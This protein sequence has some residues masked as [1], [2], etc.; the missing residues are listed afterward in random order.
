MNQYFKSTDADWVKQ[1]IVGFSLFALLAFS[2]LLARLVYL[3]AVMGEDYQRLS[4]NNSIRLQII[5]PPRGLILDAGGV[6]LAEN[7]PSFD[8]IF[9]PKDAGDARRVLGD[10]AAYLQVPDDDLLSR[11]KHTRGL[12]AF[13]PVVLRQDIG[14]DALAVVEARKVDLPGVQ[15][16]VRIRR[17]YLQGSLAAHLIGYLGE[18]SP[19]DL[20]R[21]A[22]TGLR[23]GDT[24]GKS[25]VEREFD[26]LLRGE[27]GGRQV[28]VNA[29]G[30][31]MRVLNTVAARP[32][33][34][35]H[36]TIDHMLQERTEQL[37][38]GLAAAAVA[39]DPRTGRILA[40]ASS[41][42]FSP[43]AFVGG[44]D[45]PRWEAMVSHPFR[46]LENKAIQ[47]EYP[48]G[49]TYKIV[50]ALAG[51]EEKVIDETSVFDCA[52]FLSF[53]G[54]DYRC[55][56]KEGHGRVDIRRAMAESCDVFFYRV[57]Q[58]LG[59]DRLAWYAKA[60]GLGAA[61][62]IGLEPESRGLIPS[63]VWKKKRFGVPWQDGETLSIAIGQGYNLTTPLQMAM[64]TAAVGND[65][66]RHRPQIL[67]R[68]ETME[69]ALVH[70]SQPEAL[71]KLPASPRT[72]ALIQQGLSAV[73]NGERGTARRVHINDI[74][75]AGKTGTSQVVGR[76]EG[77]D[78][79]TPPHLRPH[80]WFVCYAPVGSPR[81]AIAVVVENGE[82]GSSAAGPI[83][84][85][86]VKT[87]LRRPAAD[88]RLALEMSGTPGG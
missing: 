22:L 38:E 28:E 59:V 5:D 10:L 49:S 4:V 14:R 52:G 64:L 80:A 30:Q 36:L 56:K 33:H 16:D 42:P 66:V 70:R 69:G 60:C 31:V 21:G 7:R 27:P 58:R 85:E 75:I 47:G 11:V 18:V 19:E 12:G 54:R 71:G 50:T 1:R 32:G 88:P 81:I 84:R 83:A 48:P 25:G 20:S 24:I 77:G 72:L 55:W 37:L 3:Q 15:V 34:N 41:P 61:T 67:D 57:A 65:G 79:Y 78:D 43:N 45:A 53:A 74:E 73:V 46:A 62:G 26:A 87:Y 6:K 29:S 39:V 8:V 23:G 82:H 51:L 40:M 2:A 76:R 63:S 35:V 44:I 68:V 13:R 17:N 86:M 9:T